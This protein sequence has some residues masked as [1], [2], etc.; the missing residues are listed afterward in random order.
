MGSGMVEEKTVGGFRRVCAGRIGKS[1]PLVVESNEVGIPYLL[2]SVGVVE[3]P[4]SRSV[5]YLGG[6]GFSSWQNNVA[7]KPLQCLCVAECLLC[8]D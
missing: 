3:L 2:S 4:I 7:V 5:Q 8:T 6:V 1:G